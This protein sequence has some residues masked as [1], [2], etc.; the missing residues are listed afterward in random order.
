MPTNTPYARHAQ[1]RR[2][3]PVVVGALV[4]LVA[5]LAFCCVG[6]GVLI[7]I[8]KTGGLA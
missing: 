8:A 2:L 1:R 6:L 5:A 4:A 7:A 3:R